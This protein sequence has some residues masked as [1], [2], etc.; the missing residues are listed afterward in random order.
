MAAGNS[1]VAASLY[2]DLAESGYYGDLNSIVGHLAIALDTSKSLLDTKES[3]LNSVDTQRTSVSGVS[4]DEETTNLIVYQQS[5]NACARV[6]SAI[7][8]MLDTLI[9]SMG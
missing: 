9:N 6:I 4:V 1:E 2:A 8:E 3:L 7:D 5:Y